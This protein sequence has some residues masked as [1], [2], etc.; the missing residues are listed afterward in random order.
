MSA[1]LGMAMGTLLGGVLLALTG[2]WRVPFFIFLLPGILCVFALPCLP[3]NQPAVQKDYFKILP[4]LFKRKTLI[5]CGIGAGF[6]SIAKFAYQTWL[7][8]L[9]LRS[10]EG[11][12]PWLAGTITGSFLLV[13]VFG[14]I[15]GGTFSDSLNQRSKAGRIY[16]IVLCMTLVVSSKFLLYFLVGNISLPLLCAYGLF[17]GLL[18]MMPLP[19]YFTMAQD[20]VDDRVRSGACGV[21][22]TLIYLSGGAWGPLLIGFL[23][24]LLGGGAEGLRTAMMSLLGFMALSILIFFMAKNV[25][26]K[27]KM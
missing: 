27:E 21:L 15:I 20:V 3:D 12:S 16:A 8:V 24:D 1:P 13:G 10:Y 22:G 17:D 5:Y 23:S 9:I 4:E 14:P 26:I 11:L 2:S 6:Y 7:P 25:Y 19:I 18:T